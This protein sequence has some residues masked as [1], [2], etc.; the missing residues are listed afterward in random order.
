MRKILT[1]SFVLAAG[2]KG[3]GQFDIKKDVLLKDKQPYA[4]ITGTSKFMEPARLTVSSLNGDSLFTIRTW[5][6]PNANP[7][8]RN[9]FGYTVRF[10]GSGKSIVRLHDEAYPPT[11][12]DKIYNLVTKGFTQDLVVNNAVDPAAEAAFLKLDGAATIEKA[13]EYEKSMAEY[14]KA[15]YPVPRTTE[16]KVTLKNVKEVKE[17][18]GSITRT[19]DAYQSDVYL[20]TIVTRLTGEAVYTLQRKNDKPFTYG[21]E[22]LEETPVAVGL[23]ASSVFSYPVGNSFPVTIH[24]NLAVKDF[25]IKVAVP[26]KAELEIAQYLVD[27]KL[28]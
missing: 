28:L 15:Y 24:S 19:Q 20:V 9:L 16:A 4:Q 25:E 6:Y 10:I 5:K 11:R 18:D 8:F 7:K 3:F 12:K 2:I 22:K 26:N 14:L 1:L 17:K 27:N 21:D 23:V 13:A